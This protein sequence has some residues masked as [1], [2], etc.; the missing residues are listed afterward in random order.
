MFSVNFEHPEVLGRLSSTSL[1]DMIS[2]S[3]TVHSFLRLDNHK[4]DANR[5]FAPNCKT[6]LPLFDVFSCFC[7]APQRRDAKRPVDAVFLLTPCCRWND[8]SHSAD[9]SCPHRLKTDIFAFHAPWNLAICPPPFVQK[10][11]FQDTPG[12]PDGQ[13]FGLWMNICNRL[14]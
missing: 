8:K 5:S 1:H 10:T 3:K 11:P 4:N 12:M 9:L 6:I 7:A 14:Y 13:S 2:Y